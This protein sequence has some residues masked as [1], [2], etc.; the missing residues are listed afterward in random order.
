[1]NKLMH[2]AINKF[3][4]I[5]LRCGT[6]A[7]E[8]ESES[9]LADDS[10]QLKKRLEELLPNVE[11][12]LKHSRQLLLEITTISGEEL[13]CYAE[14]EHFFKM[15]EPMLSAMEDKKLELENI[16]NETEET[17]PKKDIIKVLHGIE[18]KA[19]AC[20]IIL[21]ELRSTLIKTGRYKIKGA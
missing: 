15:I 19:L 21:K 5:N 20:G 12:D 17:L 2:D 18:E 3:N 8:S 4:A 1:M 11:E 9:I 13:N 7:L 16:I 6:L 10:L 14:N